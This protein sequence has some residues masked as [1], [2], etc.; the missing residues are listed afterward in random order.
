MVLGHLGCRDEYESS[1]VTFNSLTFLVFVAIFAGL[2]SFTHGRSRLWLIL[3][4]SCIFYGWWDWRFLLLIGFSTTLDYWLGW[5]LGRT[6][7]P[8]RR[9]WLLSTSLVA[10]LGVLA[11]FKYFGFFVNSFVAAADSDCRQAK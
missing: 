4:S 11:F 9:R 3:T 2:Y 10:N 7:D 6:D 5:F 8:R 1:R